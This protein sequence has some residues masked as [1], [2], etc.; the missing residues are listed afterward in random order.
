VTSFLEQQFP[1]G[2]S[3]GSVSAP[4]RR[5]DIA[6]NG[7]GFEE[8]NARWANS[9][10]RYDASFG[11]KTLDQLHEVINLFEEVRGRLIGFRWKDYTDYKSCKP[12][13]T[14]S[15]ADQ[16]IGVGDGTQRAFRLIK[17]YGTINKWTR[18]ITKPVENTVQI[19]VNGILQTLAPIGT[20]GTVNVDYKTGIILFDVAPLA[21]QIIT[22]G[23]EFDVPVRF[24]TDTLS[25]STTAG[26]LG[27]IQNI[28]IV[29]IRLRLA[30]LPFD[31]SQLV[32]ENGFALLQENGSRLLV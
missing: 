1:C 14:I 4:E 30:S 26:K 21:G 11:I 12:S 7:G 19:A 9:R 17:T 31:G 10:R 16:T 13:A 20:L 8:R 6:I 28:N 23:F 27:E 24:D 29:E 22:A 3:A 25:L 5:T 18:Y 32:Q 15:N 2:I